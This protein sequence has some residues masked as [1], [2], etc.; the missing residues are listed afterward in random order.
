MIRELEG[1]ADALVVVRSPRRQIAVE[2]AHRSGEF[3]EQA[4]QDLLR[5]RLAGATGSEETEALPDFDAERQ[6]SYR[7]LFRPGVGEGQVIDSDH[8]DRTTRSTT[9]A[10][11]AHQRVTITRSR[12]GSQTT[13]LPPAP[14]AAKVA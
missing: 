8:D 1:H 11:S 6:V 14:E 5:R 3:P 13:E 10:T 2:D 4:D 12:S 9:P 7:R